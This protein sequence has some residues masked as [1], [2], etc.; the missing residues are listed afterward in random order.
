MEGVLLPV[1]P[2]PSSC[3]ATPKPRIPI[4]LRSSFPSPLLHNRFFS[5]NAAFSLRNSLRTSTF[6]LAQ[7]E[8]P[9]LGKP[10]NNNNSSPYLPKIDKTGRFCSPRAAREL[11]LSI[12]YAACLEGMDP[13]RLFEKRMN[14]RREA[15]YKFNEEKL[16]EYNHMSFGGPPVTVGSDE[17]ANELLRHIEEESAIEA[18]VLTAPPKLV[19]NKLILRFTKKLLVAVRDTWDSHVLVINKIA[20][21]NWKNE[22][23]AKILE[24][25]ILHLA[26]SEMEV[27]ETRHQIVINE[28]VDLAKRFCDGAAPRIINGC[29]RT[30]FRELELEA[31][32]NQEISPM[33]V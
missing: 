16:L 19:Y 5:Q 22:P 30:F 32:N 4:P 33:G 15:G 9:V 1:C 26:M 2:S 23:A 25:S 24:L 6:A 17:E 14:A 18:E 8:A 7:H 21:Q 3:S 10:D 28:A 13:V 11:A 20:P 12:I 29:L 31:S 27:L